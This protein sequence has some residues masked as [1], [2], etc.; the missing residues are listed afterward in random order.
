MNQT[1][2]R[3]LNITTDRA[4]LVEGYLRLTYR[5]LGSLSAEQIEDE[6]RNDISAVIDADP[7]MADFIAGSY[8]P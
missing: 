8:G 3:I 7:A 5:S 6:Y 2:A 4:R 1:I